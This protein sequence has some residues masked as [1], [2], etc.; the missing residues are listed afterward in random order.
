[1]KIDMR[2]Y[3][4][5]LQHKVVKTYNKTGSLIKLYKKDPRLL[6]GLFDL[7]TSQLS[8]K[9]GSGVI[10]SLIYIHG[11]QISFDPALGEELL[12]G[13]LGV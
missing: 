5:I 2:T 13:G 12:T 10:L 4:Y 7:N 6:L 8:Y 1:M 11:C 9:I 3:T